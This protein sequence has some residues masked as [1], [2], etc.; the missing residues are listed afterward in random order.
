MLLH[1]MKVHNR[2]CGTGGERHDMKNVRTYEKEQG[3]GE[4]VG[5]KK[6]IVK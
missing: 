2:K 4:C 6:N 5:K 1:D 3:R